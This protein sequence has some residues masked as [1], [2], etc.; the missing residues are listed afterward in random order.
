MKSIWKWFYFQ[1]GII[2]LVFCLTGCEESGN[3]KKP[4]YG[5]WESTVYP[6]RDFTNGDTV[7][8]EK[9]V[10]QFTNT[11]FKDDIYQGATSNSTSLAL[12]MAGSMNN[13]TDNILQ[14]EINEITY[15]G[16]TVKKES[17]SVLFESMFMVTLGSRLN[18]TFEATYKISQD[19][20]IFTIPVK[21]PSG[22]TIN[23]SLRLLKP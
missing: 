11:S 17:D 3:P 12:Q 21:I 15:Q 19:T 23:Q 20:L 5:T 22:G 10:F 1:S 4:Y 14:A 9:M 6:V 7:G 13:S 2:L 18:E 16:A 8:W